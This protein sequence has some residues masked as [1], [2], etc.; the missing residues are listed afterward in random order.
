MNAT[1]DFPRRGAPGAPALLH[2]PSDELRALRA[3]QKEVQN[4][5]S[6]AGRPAG[7]RILIVD[8]NRDMADSMALLLE[9]FGNHVR[10]AYGGAQALQTFRSF[11]PEVLLLDIH[12]PDID[13]L[14]VARHV[15]SLPQGDRVLM[16][17]LSGQATRRD[18]HRS[19]QAGIDHHVLKPV[20][21]I[22]LQGLIEVRAVQKRQYACEQGVVPAI[23]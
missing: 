17:A 1:L 19:R 3:S 2:R 8:D 10:T 18:K 5:V 9:Q 6:K 20:D 22:I 11:L 14:D 13:G 7:F 12:M 21:A 23:G 15:R 4:N 16:V